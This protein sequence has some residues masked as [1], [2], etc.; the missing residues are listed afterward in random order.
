MDTA[1]ALNIALR[2]GNIM[3][4][5]GAETHRVE[6]TMRRILRALG[7]ENGQAYATATGL[8][9]SAGADT[10]VAA[11]S[12]V[13]SRS[14]H[15]E[16]IARVNDLSRRLAAGETGADEIEGE[17][18][19]IE[20]LRPY[21]AWLR[22][23]GS[24]VSSFC[25]CYMLGGQWRDAICALLCGLAVF[26]AVVLLERRDISA[27][28]CNM[29]FGAVISLFTLIFINIKL[30]IHMDKIIIGAIMPLVPGI[31]MTNAIRDIMAGDFLSGVSR[32]TEAL[33]IAVAIAVGVGF[34]LWARMGAA[35]GPAI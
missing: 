11:V 32:I 29:I 26:C 34:L 16:R 27:F 30:G 12:R 3:L 13:Q 25:F 9:A 10:P 7:Q 17:L 22:I 5:N 19:Q 14:Y 18:A 15:M 33:A 24:G 1:K 6:D 4:S 35:W 20:G 23:A 21:P 8:I 28:L 31:A 2:A